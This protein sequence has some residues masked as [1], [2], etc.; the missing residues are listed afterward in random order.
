[1]K[2]IIDL[3]L[4]ALVIVLIVGCGTTSTTNTTT[5]KEEIAKKEYFEIPFKK[6]ISPAYKDETEGKYVHFKA[7]FARDMGTVNCQMAADKYKTDYIIVLL[8]DINDPLSTSFMCVIPNS[9][10][11]SVFELKLVIFWKYGHIYRKR[12][13]TH[14]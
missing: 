3:F 6:I 2:H 8:Q 5:T 11:D 4:F 12:R 13:K 10:R 1:M 14:I 9:L 7:H